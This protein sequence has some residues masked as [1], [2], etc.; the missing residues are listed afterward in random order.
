LKR[1]PATGGVAEPITTLD[2]TGVTH[3]LPVFLPD[4]KRVLFAVG[5]SAGTPNIECVDLD[6][7]KRTHVFKSDSQ[8]RVVDANHIAYL[9]DNSLVVQRFDMR[10]LKLMGRPA[11]V[12]QNVQINPYRYAADF[13]LSA[14]GTIVW[15]PRVATEANQ[16]TWFDMNGH[17]LAKLGDPS[18][19]QQLTLSRDGRRLIVCE[20]TDRFDL[21]MIDVASGVRSRFTF[22]PDPAVFPWFSSDMKSVIY[23]DALGTIFV[24]A[25]DGSGEPRKI[26]EHKT[27][28]LWPGPAAPDGS[29]I[30]VQMQRP[31][32]GI[33]IGVLS[34]SGHEDVRDLIATPGNQDRAVFSPDGRWL[35]YES[36]ETGRRD[37]V[38]VRYPSLQGRWQV[39]SGG[40]GG[41][42]WMPDGRAILYT[43]DDGHIMRVEVDGRGDGLV[44]GA[45]STVLGG[46]TIS[47]GFDV[48]PDGKRLLVIVPQSSGAAQS[49]NL[50]TDW[51]QLVSE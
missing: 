36:D 48:A 16:L 23:G 6:T 11:P 51:R 17:E 12:A 35:A 28:S 4:G 44:V 30:L 9:T 47:T 34:L 50:V 32:T 29:S 31:A 19:A 2:S 21:A 43:T 15:Y 8:V 38:V 20:R 33:D 49:L 41:P 18:P 10:A 14:S 1:V 27:T 7:K 25:A 24:R 22:G 39:S 46:K 26:V 5:R 45:T 3:R 13:D 42:L 40:G 37:V